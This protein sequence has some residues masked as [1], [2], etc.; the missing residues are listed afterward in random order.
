M[1]EK[2]QPLA[3]QELDQTT[4]GDSAEHYQ[5]P[6][7]RHKYQ[8]PKCNGTSFKRGKETID[9]W[10]LKRKIKE[11][12]ECTTCGAHYPI[13]GQNSLIMLD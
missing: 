8:C 4:G 7:I 11:W 13:S 5:D 10:P 9:Y 6:K 3:E 1:T 12:L 2:T